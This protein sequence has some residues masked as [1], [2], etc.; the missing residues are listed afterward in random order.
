MSTD[1]YLHV[2]TKRAGKAKGEAASAGHEGDIL[3]R[4]W[5]WGVNASSALGS[6]NAPG[7]SYKQLTVEKNV[8]A[9][10]TALLNALVKNDEVKEAKLTMRK[11]GEGQVDYFT[12]TL[13]NARIVSVDLGSDES[14]STTERVSLSFTAV[15]IE[16]R[17]QQGTGSSGASHTF[18]DDL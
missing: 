2:Q 13:K 1:T 5:N 16:Y 7:R 8:D 14:G 17:P 6:L 15:E 3:V 11:A 10:S 4:S 9:A 18:S 12:L